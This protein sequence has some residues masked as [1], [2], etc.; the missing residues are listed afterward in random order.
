MEA[1][2]FMRSGPGGKR[3][4]ARRQ[5]GRKIVDREAAHAIA[6]AAKGNR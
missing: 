6:A 1:C 3:W 2:A 4:R 5:A